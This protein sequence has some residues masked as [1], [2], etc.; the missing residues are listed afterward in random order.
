M[1]RVAVDHDR[2][3]VALVHAHSS[4]VGQVEHVVVLVSEERIVRPGPLDLEQH[5]DLVLEVLQELAVDVQAG[6]ARPWQVDEHQ[7]LDVYLRESAVNPHVTHCVVGP[8]L[9]RGINRIGDVGAKLGQ[10][11]DF[12]RPVRAGQQPAVAGE[13]VLGVV[14]P[15]QEFLLAHQPLVL[16]FAARRQVL[17]FVPGEFVR[18]PGDGALAS[19][20]RVQR[21]QVAVPEFLPGEHRNLRVG[22]AWAVQDTAPRGRRRIQRGGRDGFL[23]EVGDRAQQ[24]ALPGLGPANHTDVHRVAVDPV[25]DRRDVRRQRADRLPQ[26]ADPG[27]VG[28]G[29]DRLGQRGLLRGGLAQRRELLARLDERAGQCFHTF[30]QCLP[31]TVQPC[32]GLSLGPPAVQRVRDADP[33]MSVHYAPVKPPR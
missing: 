2:D 10:P 21:R 26:F 3:E 25:L 13:R 32:D 18:R 16:G 20:V 5:V 27:R 12:Q 28:L 24:R 23:A 1:R 29:P 15:L 7:V 30:R 8:P 31:G 9:V 19:R 14:Q 22:P 17:V 4:L 33:D 6:L 11:V